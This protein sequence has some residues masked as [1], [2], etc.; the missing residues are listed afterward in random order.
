[1]ADGVRTLDTSLVQILINYPGDEHG[2]NWHHRVLLQR[3]DG[4]R[5]FGLTPELNIRE[6]DLAAL[7]HRVVDRASFFPADIEDEC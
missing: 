7:P 4:A 3:I 1:M 2:F 5:W 6:Y